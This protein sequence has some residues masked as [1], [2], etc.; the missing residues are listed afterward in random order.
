MLVSSM[1]EEVKAC[2]VGGRSGNGFG[3]TV[4]GRITERKEYVG[5]GKR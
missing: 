1:A 2:A 5:E 4:A 3:R